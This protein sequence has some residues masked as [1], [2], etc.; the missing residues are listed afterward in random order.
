MAC[1]IFLVVLV[2]NLV[3]TG[4]YN[5]FI[6]FFQASTIVVYPGL[7]MNFHLADWCA[8][9][10]FYDLIA[11]ELMCNSLQPALNNTVKQ[12]DGTQLHVS[13]LE[14]RR[15]LCTGSRKYQRDVE[16]SCISNSICV[17]HY[18]CSPFVETRTV[19][20]KELL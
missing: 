8:M 11:L 17:V 2:V 10:R 14:S 18:M 1:W 9:A 4:P 12:F 20:R 6:P 13:I 15:K 3:S 7:T 19:L 5:G 16:V